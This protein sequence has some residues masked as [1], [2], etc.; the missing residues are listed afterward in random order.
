MTRPFPRAKS[1]W[2]SLGC[3]P[4]IETASLLLLSPGWA[5]ALQT[6][7]ILKTLVA[8]GFCIQQPKTKAYRLSSRLLEWASPQVG[9]AWLAVVA[10]G[11]LCQLRDA[12]GETAQ[13]VIESA[14][15]TGVVGPILTSRKS[16]FLLFGGPAPSGFAAPLPCC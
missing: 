6:F 5:A 4:R 2:L 3:L 9:D 15:K 14:R 7:C 1:C 10:Y 8:C 13:L 16:R 11:P 12:T